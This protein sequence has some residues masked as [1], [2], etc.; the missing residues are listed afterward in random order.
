[1]GVERIC[2]RA[3]LDNHV[4]ASELIGC[5]RREGVARDLVVEI[6]EH[7]DDSAVRHGDDLRPII[8]LVQLGE[9]SFLV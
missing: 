4:I 3:D 6:V 5:E 9:I 1:V 2:P 8:E 7:F